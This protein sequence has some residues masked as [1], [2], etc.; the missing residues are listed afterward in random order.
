MVDFSSD[1]KSQNAKHMQDSTTITD[2]LKYIFKKVISFL[3]R[4]S[5]K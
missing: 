1:E 4:N 2:N 5:Q 3:R